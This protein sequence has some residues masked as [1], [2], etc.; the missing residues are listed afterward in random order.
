MS[1]EMHYSSCLQTVVKKEKEA[2]T[3][4]F[5]YQVS[6]SVNKVTL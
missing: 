4:V 6:I 1:D 2:A 3:N 5:E